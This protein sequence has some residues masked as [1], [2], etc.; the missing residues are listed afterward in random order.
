MQNLVDP[1]RIYPDQNGAW[2]YLVQSWWIPKSGNQGGVRGVSPRWGGLGGSPPHLFVTA[3]TDAIEFSPNKMV[4]PD[5]NGR[6]NVFVRYGEN[7]VPAF[8]PS[9]GWLYPYKKNAIDFLPTILVEPDQN[10]WG[11][12]FWLGLGL[13]I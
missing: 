9:S 5:Q 7:K 11:F 1:H 4:Q 3:L 12:F 2:T 13:G 10:V 8:L 6:Q